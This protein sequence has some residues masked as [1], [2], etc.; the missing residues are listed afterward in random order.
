MLITRLRAKQTCPRRCIHSTR[1]MILIWR[2]QKRMCPPPPRPTR[3]SHIRHSFPR[4]EAR[5]W[6]IMRPATGRLWIA[7]RPKRF[8]PC[9]PQTHRHAMR[10]SPSWM[11]P[12]VIMRTMMS[13]FMIVTTIRTC[14]TRNG[15]AQLSRAPNWIA[16][17]MSLKSVNIWRARRGSFWPGSWSSMS[18]RL[19]F[20][21]RTS[22]PK[23][24]SLVVPRI[25]WL[26]SWQHKAYTTMVPT[27]NKR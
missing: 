17:R 14:P 5:W 13:M 23:L 24:K 22:G 9:R 25:I 20:G 26:S 1:T 11:L 15:L 6:P 27:R 12:I 21:S 16:S 7:R 2:R 19:K 10:V 18:R 4:R 8:W 3:H